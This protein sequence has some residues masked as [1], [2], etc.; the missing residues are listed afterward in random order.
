MMKKQGWK[1]RPLCLQRKP[2]ETIVETLHSVPPVVFI[3]RPSRKTN[4]LN[5]APFNYQNS[6]SWVKTNSGKDL[7]RWFCF[8]RTV[9]VANNQ[10]FCCCEV[11][12]RE[13]ANLV[14]FK[15]LVLLI[16]IKTKITTILKETRFRQLS[17]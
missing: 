8:M 11:R 12:W 14:S 1:I 4:N 15:M 5:K 2:K 6:S 9:E 3:T 7:K 16:Q 13:L 10:I 17:S